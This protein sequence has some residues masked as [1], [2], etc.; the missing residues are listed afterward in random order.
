MEFKGQIVQSALWCLIESL[1]MAWSS[2]YLHP[3]CQG[4]RYLLREYIQST[5]DTEYYTLTSYLSSW[6]STYLSYHLGPCKDIVWCYSK[7]PI[8]THFSSIGYLS[9]ISQTIPHGTFYSLHFLFCNMTLL[10]DYWIP[11]FECW[12]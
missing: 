4:S 3:H 6:T 10:P 7:W 1:L 8:M 9:W 12:I 2:G 11:L 5:D